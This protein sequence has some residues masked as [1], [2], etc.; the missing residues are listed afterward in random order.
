MEIFV[1]CQAGGTKKYL[2]IVLKSVYNNYTLQEIEHMV[3]GDS[4]VH[5][6]GFDED[7]DISQICLV[8]DTGIFRRIDIIEEVD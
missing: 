6:S 1:M 2:V 5:V 4:H 7:T 3:V 8:D